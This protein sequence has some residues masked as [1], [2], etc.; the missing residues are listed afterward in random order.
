MSENRVTSKS[1][2][3]SPQILQNKNW[4]MNFKTTSSNKR[5]EIYPFQVSLSSVQ[6]W[7]IPIQTS[8]IN[9][10]EIV[11][12]WELIDWPSDLHSGIFMLC[13]IQNS[14]RHNQKHPIR[15]LSSLCE[16]YRH[17]VVHHPVSRSFSQCVYGYKPSLH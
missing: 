7:Q 6:K 4:R 8:P 11:I 15:K 16:T 2:N 10:S 17:W 5:W 1:R 13:W 3:L 9:E 12:M 14:T